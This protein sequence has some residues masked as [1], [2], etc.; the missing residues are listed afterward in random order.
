MIADRADMGVVVGHG[1]HL[2]LLAH[3]STSSG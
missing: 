3:P 2:F 1:C